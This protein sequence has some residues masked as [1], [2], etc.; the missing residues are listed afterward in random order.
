[1]KYYCYEKSRVIRPVLATKIKTA[2]LQ[3]E[4]VKKHQMQSQQNNAC[5][6][7]RQRFHS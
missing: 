5:Y 6:I 7:P 3:Y 4:A 2:V 1:M